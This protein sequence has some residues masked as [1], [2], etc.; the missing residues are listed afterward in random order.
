MKT[1]TFKLSP[2]VK[3]VLLG[4]HYSDFTPMDEL[5]LCVGLLMMNESKTTEKYTLLYD[6]MITLSSIVAEERLKND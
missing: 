3:E 5:E 2:K 1:E 4:I 6:A